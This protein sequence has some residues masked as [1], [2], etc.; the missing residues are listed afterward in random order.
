MSSLDAVP[1][2]L[3]E[4]VFALL[5]PAAVIRSLRV[6]KRFNGLIKANE[7]KMRKM[8]VAVQLFLPRF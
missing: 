4:N 7:N 5:P 8:G 2:K 6:C 1:N 3:L